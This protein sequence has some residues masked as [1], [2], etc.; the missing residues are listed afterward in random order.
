M[1]VCVHTS[2]T[3]VE[4]Y[5][6]IDVYEYA[7]APR[8]DVYANSLACVYLYCTSTDLQ[9]SEL[10]STSTRWFRLWV[11]L[12]WVP[13]VIVSPKGSVYEQRDTRTRGL[14]KGL[15][16]P[17]FGAYVWTTVVF[18]LFDIGGAS[19]TVRTWKQATPALQ[20]QLLE[21]TILPHADKASGDTASDP[22]VQATQHHS[23]RPRLRQGSGCSRFRASTVIRGFE[24]AG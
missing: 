2:Y 1:R 8:A 12:F 9:P 13:A 15:P 19:L 23:M 17:H 4:M 6:D 18:R 10:S 24:A 20:H 11:P 14:L 16:F 22:V 3:D 5:M 7:R 21:W